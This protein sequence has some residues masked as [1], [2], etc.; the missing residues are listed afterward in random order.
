V[1]APR[2]EHLVEPQPVDRARVRV[3]LAR[4]EDGQ[5]AGARAAL[6]RHAEQRPRHLVE[7]AVEVDPVDRPPRRDD[8]K[9]GLRQRRA[10]LVADGGEGLL[11]RPLLVAHLEP[12]EVRVP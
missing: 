6:G 1:A 9:Q 4:E 8:R 5:R 10:G 2:R 3:Q 7:L 11:G 12:H